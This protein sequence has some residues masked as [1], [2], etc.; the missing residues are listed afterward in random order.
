MLQHEVLLQ[1]GMPALS[2]PWLSLVWSLPQSACREIAGNGWHP[3][4][5][6]AVLLTALCNAEL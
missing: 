3:A 5:Y 4:M 1:M 2:E 6:L